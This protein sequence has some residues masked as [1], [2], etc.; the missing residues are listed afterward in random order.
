M[1]LEVLSLGMTFAPTQRFNLF[2]TILDVNRLVRNLTI[3]KHFLV[4]PNNDAVVP[5][6]ESHATVYAE[7]HVLL[8][9]CTNFN[10]QIAHMN[11]YLLNVESNRN[12]S[13]NTSENFSTR[14]STFYPTQARSLALESFQHVVQDALVELHHRPVANI[15]SRCNMN[16]A[17]QNALTQILKIDDL[18]IRQA[19]KGGDVVALDK[20]LYIQ[21][22]INMLSDINTYRKLESDPTPIFKQKLEK[23]IFEGLSIGVITA[24]QAKYLLVENP[25]LPVFHSLP[26]LHKLG[27]PPAMRPIVSGIDSLNENLCS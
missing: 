1:Q 13:I 15:D 10:E 24:K 7:S 14:N 11:L 3:K 2:E 21:Q 18:V 20:G 16:Q 25:R 17:Q 4:E 27:F 12:Y 5:E 9:V 6:V 23:L 8:F 22:N 26:K 19:D